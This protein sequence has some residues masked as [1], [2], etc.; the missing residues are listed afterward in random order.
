MH[1]Y[2]LNRNSTLHYTGLHI[3]Q[4]QILFSVSCQPSSYAMQAQVQAM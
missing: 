4:D 3:M 2:V 1:V